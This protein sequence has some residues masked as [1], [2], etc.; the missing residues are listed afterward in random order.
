MIDVIKITDPGAIVNLIPKIEE[1]VNIIESKGIYQSA[2]TTYLM[3]TVSSGMGEFWVAIK[4]EK[5][6]GFIRFSMLGLPYI[7]DICVDAIYSWSD[8]REVA[9]A[10]C[11]KSVEFARQCN[12]ERIHASFYNRNLFDHFK[13]SLKNILDIEMTDINVIHGVGVIK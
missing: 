3:Q 8:D 13:K 2:F 5:P 9:N 7:S 4:D 12:A 1:Y 10:L 6:K 11:N